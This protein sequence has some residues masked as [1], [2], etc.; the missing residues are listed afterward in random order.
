MSNQSHG[1][2]SH[3]KVFFKNFSLVMGVLF[4]I[5]FLCIIVARIITP[6]RELDAAGLAKLEAATAPVGEVV[7]DP[8]ALELKLAANKPARAAYTGEQVVTKVCAACHQ[9]GM[10]NA[11]KIGD[12][13]EWAKRK[14]AAGGL[15]GL[16]KLA[17]KGINQMPARGGDSDLSD[18][19][20]KA[21][22]EFILSK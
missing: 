20:M 11:P 2:E 17:I 15:D 19:E 22:V 18:D 14:G 16:V 3:D 1:N 6:A 21:A 9:T 7:T 8:A 10:L 4:G 12:K 5:F 13:G